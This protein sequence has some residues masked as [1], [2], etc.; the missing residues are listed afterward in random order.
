MVLIM[1]DISA[2]GPKELTGSPLFVTRMVLSSPTM[3]FH[4]LVYERVAE[5][6]RVLLVDIAS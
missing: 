3:K 5:V 1:A 6:D 2:I 4:R